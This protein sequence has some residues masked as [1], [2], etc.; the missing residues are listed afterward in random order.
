MHKTHTD[1]DGADPLRNVMW[2]GHKFFLLWGM[3]I[4]FHVKCHGRNTSGFELDR[5]VDVAAVIAYD[6]RH[7]GMSLLMAASLYIACA[8]I[9]AAAA[10][11]T[12]SAYASVRRSAPGRPR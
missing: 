10:T 1:G 11:Q 4:Y 12:G 6:D 8:R 3:F 9:A 7:R 5:V 2:R